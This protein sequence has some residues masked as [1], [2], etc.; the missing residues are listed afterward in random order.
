MKD[1]D[2]RAVALLLDEAERQPGPEGPRG[3]AGTPGAPG[4]IGLAGPEGPRGRDGRDGKDGERGLVGPPGPAGKDGERGPAGPVGATGPTGDRGEP[5]QDG[6]GADERV[7]VAS[8]DPT[9]GFLADKLV[10]GLGV[11]LRRERR[12]RGDAL[13]IDAFGGGAGGIGPPG[14]PGPAGD[15]ATISASDE[16]TDLGSVQRFDFVG[17]GVTAVAAAGVATI[18]VPGTPATLDVQLHGWDG[19]AWVPVLATADG[20][21]RVTS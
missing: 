16:G 19:S 15:D 20:R 14:P 8:D 2:A 13:V 6:V 3:P 17:P 10:G 5:G 11:K 4:P 7:R 9:P 1:L 21:L 18:T 12:E